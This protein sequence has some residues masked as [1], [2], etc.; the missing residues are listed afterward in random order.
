MIS[1]YTKI[2]KLFLFFSDTQNY[3]I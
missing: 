2:P 3:F 1:F